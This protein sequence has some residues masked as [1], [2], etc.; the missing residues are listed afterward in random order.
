MSSLS[1]NFAR[2]RPHQGIARRLANPI[3]IAAL[4]AQLPATFTDFLTRLRDLE[5]LGLSTVQNGPPVSSLTHTAPLLTRCPVVHALVARCT[6]EVHHRD[7]VTSAIKTDILPMTAQQ[8]MMWLP[9][10]G[11][12]A[13]E[14]LCFFFN[15]P[16]LPLIK[17]W[18]EKVGEVIALVDSGASVRAV[19]LSVVRKLLDPNR[20]TNK[21][22]LRGVDNRVVLGEGLDN[23]G[24]KIWNGKG[25]RIVEAEGGKI[26]KESKGKKVRLVNDVYIINEEVEEEKVSVCDEKEKRKVVDLVQVGVE[27]EE[28][29][30]EE[31]EE[32]IIGNDLCDYVAVAEQSSLRR[33]GLMTVQVQ[34]VRQ[35]IPPNSLVFVKG[36]LSCEVSG[37]GFVKF[38]CCSKPRK[39]WVIPS[40]AVKIS[41]GVVYIAILNYAAVELKFRRRHFMC[42]LEV[43]ENTEL[44]NASETHKEVCATYLPENR[45]SELASRVKI[46]EELDPTEREKL[47]FA[48]ASAKIIA[49]KVEEMLED[50]VIEDSLSPWSSPVV[51]VRK[52]KSGEYRFCVDFRRLNASQI[53]CLND[54]SSGSIL[55]SPWLGRSVKVFVQSYLFC[56]K[57]KHAIGHVNFKLLPIEPPSSPSLPI[58]V[59]HLGPF[60]MTST[61]YRHI[62]V[63]IDYLTK[64]IEVQPVPDTSSK[65]PSAF[66]KQ[67]V[68]FRHGAPQRLI[69][70]QGMAFTSEQFSV[71]TKGWNINQSF[72]TEEH[73]ET[74]GMVERVNRTLTLAFCA[75]IITIHDDWDSHLSAAAFA[76]N[77]A[78]QATTEIAPFELVHGRPPFLFIVNLFP[79]PDEE[80]ESHSQFLTRVADLRMAAR[81][82]ILRKQRITKERDDRRRKVDTELL[83]GDLVLVRRKPHKKNLT[84]KWLPKVIGPF[85]VVKKVC[86]TTYSMEDFP[87]LRKKNS[88]WWFNAHVCQIRRFHGRS[89]LEWDES[90]DESSSSSSSSSEVNSSESE[91]EPPE[92]QPIVTPLAVTRA[93]RQRRQPVW[94]RHYHT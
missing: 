2:G 16:G 82:R 85:Q 17:V 83:I 58:G 65:F 19:R 3:Y 62:I 26:L 93:G 49:D 6:R 46:G 23:E 5:Q 50:G 70:D 72:A 66:L 76:I 28:E 63:A 37:T 81:V 73:P 57:Y 31:K 30:Y 25:S 10:N 22:K 14:R 11:N 20:K 52:V 54:L 91:D 68:L 40:S 39:E 1:C 86:P 61:G 77:T 64:W 78:R 48:R 32:F 88:H 80:K 36:I 42:T 21:T 12:G 41:N 71:W 55:V 47:L 56:Q 75:F 7:F 69:T 29:K 53:V 59:D 8:K 74:N 15:R 43:D 60:K 51:L 4:T 35:T 38:H 90:E 18:N 89:D 92:T 45:G 27:R 84:K 94:M 33:R 79:W 13:L 87:A 34:T 9:S 24:S 44:P 67:N